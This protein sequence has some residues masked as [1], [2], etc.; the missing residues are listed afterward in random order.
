MT[1][2]GVFNRCRDWELINNQKGISEKPL[3]IEWKDLA[4]TYYKIC[5]K[6]DVI[7]AVHYM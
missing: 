5:N 6:Y 7:N 2:D 1:E 3:N 4:T